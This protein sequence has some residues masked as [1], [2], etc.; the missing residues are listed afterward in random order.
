MHAT[1]SSLSD[2]VFM[3]ICCFTLAETILGLITISLTLVSACD[4]SVALPS[5]SSNVICNSMR[6]QWVTD[7][8]CLDY[9]CRP[10]TSLTDKPQLQLV[11]DCPVHTLGS[12]QRIL[13]QVNQLSLTITDWRCSLNV[14]LVAIY[15][16]GLLR[17]MDTVFNG[18][19]FLHQNSLLKVSFLLY[20]H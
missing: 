4:C 2:W 20:S 3:V 13:F 19:M 11:M 18:A 5:A 6:V 1:W 14:D 9:I 8:W 17:T 16:Y 7:T 10:R 12:V 15:M